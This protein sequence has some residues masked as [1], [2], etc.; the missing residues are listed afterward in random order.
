[1]INVEIVSKNGGVYATT[2][3]DVVR[4][5]SKDARQILAEENT[6]FELKFPNVDI[7]GSI[8]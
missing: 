1:M 4:A 7:M 2:D 6:V 3:F 5:M 8:K